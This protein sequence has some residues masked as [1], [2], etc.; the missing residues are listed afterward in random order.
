MKDEQIGFDKLIKNF[1][2]SNN[3]TQI[4]L[5]K[6]LKRNQTTISNYEKGIHFPNVPEEIKGIADLLN[7]PVSY[8]IDSIKFSR[9]GI[10]SKNDPLEINLDSISDGDFDKKYKFVFEG[11]QLTNEELEKILKLIKFERFAMTNR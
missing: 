1:R 10:L 8:I 6:K 7:H 9:T 5:A 3:L 11:K 4:D 2:K